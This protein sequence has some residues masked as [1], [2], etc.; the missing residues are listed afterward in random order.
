[1]TQIEQLLQDILD[2][3]TERGWDNPL[4]ST[5]SKSICLEAAELLEHFQWSEPSSEQILDDPQKLAKVQSELADVLIYCLQMAIILK[6]DPEKVIRDKLRK[7]MLKYP[8]SSVK[9]RDDE[10]YRLKEQARLKGIN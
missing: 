1:M 10:Y 4:P 8:V 9:G 5:L 3:L 6:L 2:Y 7:V